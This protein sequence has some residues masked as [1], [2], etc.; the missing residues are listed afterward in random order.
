MAKAKA[1]ELN[2]AMSK[3][4]RILLKGQNKQPIILGEIVKGE[5]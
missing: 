1:N 5:S 2:K 3:I 4:T